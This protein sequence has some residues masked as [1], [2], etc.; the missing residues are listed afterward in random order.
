MCP[1][2]KIRKLEFLPQM[3]SLF[4]KPQSIQQAFLI[5]QCR[6]FP[7]DY[8]L[9]HFTEYDGWDMKAFITM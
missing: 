1:R 3:F 2:V 5:R 4:Y 7:C 6:I 8:I 9:F